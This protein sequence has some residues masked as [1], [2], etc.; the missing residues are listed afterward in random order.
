LENIDK[1][2][3]LLDLTFFSGENKNYCIYHI[4][5]VRTSLNRPGKKSGKLETNAESA[6]S[7]KEKN[8]I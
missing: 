7:L 6:I 2:F 1:T 5:K 3:R 4:F 8:L